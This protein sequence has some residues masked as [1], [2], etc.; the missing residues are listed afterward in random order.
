[1]ENQLCNDPNLFTILIPTKDRP[2]FLKRALGFLYSQGFLGQILVIDGSNDDI[3]FD[4]QQIVNNQATLNTIYIHTNLGNAWTEMYQGLKG[5][6]SKYSL[7]Y[8]DD[9]FFFLDEI[10][11][12]I[13]F[14]ENNDDY[15]SA[16]GRFVFIN[17]SQNKEIELVSQQ[18]FSYTNA[19]NEHRLMD[20]FNRYC[21]LFFSV[22]PREVFLQIA[23][24]IPKYLDYGWFDQFAHSLLIG[25][26]GKSYTSDG[27]FCIRQCHPE[28]THRRMIQNTPHLYF[29]QILASPDFSNIYQNFRKCLIRG[30]R[31]YVSVDDEKLGHILDQG[32]LLLLKRG[33]VGKAPPEQQDLD[34]IKRLKEPNSIEQQKVGQVLSYL[35]RAPT[36]LR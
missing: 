1:M 25:V 5:I 13:D 21:H 31:D 35:M 4:N 6:T 16:K 2:A 15:V 20:I 30:C 32:L 9:D 36:E 17:Q 23:D 33:F 19:T 14:L 12:C 34:V 29:P 8:H 27:L 10:D 3:S 22:T 18:M 7:L 26:H 24:Q 28:Q 11:R